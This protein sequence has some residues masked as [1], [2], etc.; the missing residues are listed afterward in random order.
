MGFNQRQ[1]AGKFTR[2][3]AVALIEQLESAE[4]PPPDPRPRPAPR[5][6]RPSPPAAPTA[7]TA[8]PINLHDLDDRALANEL[9]RRG[10][11]VIAP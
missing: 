6:R 1:A 7:T 8:A 4:S 11:I 5:P 2:D 9:E 10:W 3:E